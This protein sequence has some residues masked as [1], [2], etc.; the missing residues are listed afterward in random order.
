MLLKI[1]TA[2]LS[3]LAL[4][5]N[6]HKLVVG[7][8]GGPDSLALLH[9]LSR[10][11]APQQLV[12]AHLNHT[13]R[14]ASDA[15]AKMV[16]N[17]AAVWGIECCTEKVDIKNLAQENGWSLEEAGRIA[18]YRFLAQTAR[19]A[20]ATA[21]AV[22]HHADDQAETVLLHLL[23]GS[24]LDGLAGMRPIGSVP[25][26]P[27]MVLVRPLLQASRSKIEAYC[28]AHKL[29]PVYDESNIDNRFLRNRVRNELLPLLAEYNP[30]IRRQLTQLT[31]VA[32]AD[33]DY[34]R[35]LT[36]TAWTT[37]VQAEEAGWVRLDLTAWQALSLSL[38]RRTLRRAA[39]RTAPAQTELP[40]LPLEQA[41]RVAETGQTGAQA[42][43][44]GG[45]LLTVRYDVIEISAADFP[46]N[47][48]APQ[49]PED[50]ALELSIP[51]RV[52][53]SS[54]WLI[55]ADVLTAWDLDNIRRNRD[56]WLAFVDVGDRASLQLRARQLGELLQPLGMSGQ[57]KKIK[58]LMINRKL[59][60]PARAHWPIVATAQ[61]PVWVVG[62]QIDERARVT[63]VTERVVRLRCR[64]PD[65][66]AGG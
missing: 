22:A 6:Q 35:E 48:T 18:R 13:I 28:A 62:V 5:L 9:V 46:I 51:G 16:Q 49:L 56:S 1:V 31:A 4:P 54:G 2:V 17:T 47:Q 20:G 14:P 36:Q 39:L 55:E 57:T 66:D 11:L 27:E 40:F 61:F 29:Y 33:V 19:A 65:E 30:Q 34:L 45:V 25:G 58:N 37:I 26:A 41:R 59:A 52:K 3:Q 64:R 21:V 12:A 15:E 60:A 42:T 53:L 8:S 32:A 50:A 38:R 10:I 43:L 24:G 23:R 44:P 63:A 7:I